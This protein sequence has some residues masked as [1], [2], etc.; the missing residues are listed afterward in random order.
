MEQLTSTTFYGQY[1]RVWCGSRGRQGYTGGYTK[2]LPL[3]SKSH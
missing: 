1:R 3:K 2:K